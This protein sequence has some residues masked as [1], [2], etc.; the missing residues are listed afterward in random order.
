MCV[1]LGHNVKQR[2]FKYLNWVGMRGRFLAHKLGPGAR[3]FIASWLI[4]HWAVN[5]GLITSDTIIVSDVMTPWI[6]YWFMHI[7]YASQLQQDMSRTYDYTVASLD[8]NAHTTS[9]R[10]IEPIVN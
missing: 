1:R 9:S 7:A 4:R 3:A 5:T 10:P 8:I 6:D 2:M